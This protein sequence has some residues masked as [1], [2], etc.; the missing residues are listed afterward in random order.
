MYFRQVFNL[1]K[2][3]TMALMK[4]IE[5]VIKT[6]QIGKA[7]AANKKVVESKK[8]SE[9]IEKIKKRKEELGVSWR[10]IAKNTEKG[11]RWESLWQVI[12]GRRNLT[13]KCE[14]Q[15]MDAFDKIE[16]KRNGVVVEEKPEQENKGCFAEVRYLPE[17]SLSEQK[18]V[19]PMFKKKE[20]DSKD[21]IR[22][23]IIGI[24]KARTL[25]KEVVSNETFVRKEFF[26]ILL[27]LDNELDELVDSILEV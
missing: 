23:R 7:V 3:V 5:G 16:K 8:I 27:K 24:K 18:I 1:S 11:Y 9:R 12:T 4:K 20:L 13:D 14:K 26:D 15:V 2:P 19:M 10:E 21:L 25:V 17:S 6:Y 22:G